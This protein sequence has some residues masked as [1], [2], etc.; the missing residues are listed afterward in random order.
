MN[1]DKKVSRKVDFQQNNN[2]IA[3]QTTKNVSEL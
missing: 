1:S 3:P 2:K